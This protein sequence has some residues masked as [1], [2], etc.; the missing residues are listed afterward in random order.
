ME[1]QSGVVE[2]QPGTKETHTR[3]KDA[4][5]GVLQT[6]ADDDRIMIDKSLFQNRAHLFRRPIKPL[7][8]PTD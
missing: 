4:H 5:P 2:A 3:A 8:R 7:G 1:A 6:V